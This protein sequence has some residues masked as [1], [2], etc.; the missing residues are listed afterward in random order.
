[1]RMCY[2]QSVKLR[3]F[4]PLDFMGLKQFPKGMALGLKQTM[5]VSGNLTDPKKMALKNLM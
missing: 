2:G 3:I 1:M 5:F 4:S